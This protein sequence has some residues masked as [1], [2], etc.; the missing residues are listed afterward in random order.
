VLD[1]RAE[2]E[3]TGEHAR[4][5]ELRPVVALAWRRARL[6]S[7]AQL[8]HDD[9]RLRGALLLQAEARPLDL[10][11]DTDRGVTLDLSAGSGVRL[12]SFLERFP[13]G[14]A[15]V[16]GNPDL[17]PE[18]HHEARMVL[19]A[20]IG[21]PERRLRVETGLLQRDSRELIVWRQTNAAAWKP[22]NL[23]EARLRQW[24]GGLSARLGAHWAASGEL[25]LRD[26]R[27]LAA[28][29]NHGRYLTHQP[30]HAWQARVDWN[31][32]PDTRGLRV[33]LDAEGAGRSYSGES[34]LEGLD[35][36]ALDPWWELGAEL[37]GRA[38]N[39]TLD[40][41]WSVS[42]DNLLDRD[43]RQVPKVPLPGRAFRVNLWFGH[44]G[45]L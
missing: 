12:P 31:R 41:G 25:R 18:Q 14:G 26:P 15:Q 13:V 39:P 8:W 19:A 44:T 4:R 3:G 9:R 45:E 20:W 42:V 33:S 29:I 36:A 6:E 27:N 43:V 30:L 10:G 34:N 35:G 22:F 24:H 17:E 11:R 16:L 5:L 1:Y 38:G 23:G 40:W 37:A 28:G 32:G 21:G 7:G 2:S